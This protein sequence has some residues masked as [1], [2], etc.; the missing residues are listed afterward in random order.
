MY[1]LTIRLQLPQTPY[2]GIA[3]DHTGDPALQV[4]M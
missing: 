3:L 2:R 4:C 1:Q